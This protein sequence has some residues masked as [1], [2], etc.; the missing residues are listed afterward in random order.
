MDQSIALSN[1]LRDGS[2]VEGSLIVMEDFCHVIGDDGL[3]VALNL[4]STGGGEEG[5]AGVDVL[6]LNFSL[7]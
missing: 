2:S 3:V 4:C 1:S 5:V 6:I 7:K